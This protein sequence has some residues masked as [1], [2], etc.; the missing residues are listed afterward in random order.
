MQKGRIQVSPQHGVR[1]LTLGTRVSLDGAT[2]QSVEKTGVII[3]RT[4]VA[5]TRRRSAPTLIGETRDAG[6]RPRILR[7]D[8]TP[9]HF[10]PWPPTNIMT[11]IAEGFEA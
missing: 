5:L 7:T 10:G 9:S 4:A 6:L 11:M 2:G 8:L 1:S 3:G